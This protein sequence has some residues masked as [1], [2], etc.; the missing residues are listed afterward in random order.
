[1]DDD[2]ARSLL[3]EE[4]ARLEDLKRRVESAGDAG[5]EDDLSE[6]STADQHSADVGSETFER[7]KD[8][9]VAE[10]VAGQLED[11]ERA[12]EKLAAGTYGACEV[13]GT[14]I[15]DERLEAV[16]AARYCIEHQAAHE[17]GAPAG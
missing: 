15:P 5:Q 14:A 6:L 9:S 11:V 4:R 16:P 8:L 17:Q 13:C 12:L 10:D 1:M 3:T 2:R 7:T